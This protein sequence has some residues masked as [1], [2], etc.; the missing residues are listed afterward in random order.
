MV[1]KYPVEI[2]REEFEESI[3]SLIA[4]AVLQCESALD[5][6]NLTPSDIDGVFLA[7]GSTRIPLVAENV[8]KVFQKKP[9]SVVNVDEVVA[10][11]ASLY[12]AYKSDKKH[13]SPLQKNSVNKLSVSEL[14]SHY[15]GVE[16]LIHN[17][18]KNDHELQ[19][20][21][22]INKNESIPC[23]KT[24][25]FYTTS[26]GQE[27][28]Q[29]TITQS[30]SKET[31]IRFV[32][33]VWEGSLKLPSGRPKNQQIDITYSYDDNQIMHCEFVDVASGNKEKVDLGNKVLRSESSSS[34]D[35]F[36]VE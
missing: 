36:T 18:S 31:D 33:K 14:T 8:E 20:S 3:S 2:K 1:G 7:G 28:V 26:D 35:K 34:I 30:A 24:E 21:I 16:A 6:A 11:G 4:Q 17:D 15:F 25:P 19:N 13:L 23:L 10:L 5:E 27:S 29:C 9:V 22:I 32:T 12:A